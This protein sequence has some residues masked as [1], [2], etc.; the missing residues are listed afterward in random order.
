MEEA[1]KQFL[2]AATNPFY[3]APE[4]PYANIGTCAHRHGQPDKAADY[5]TRALLLNPNIPS[6][7]FSMS[8]INYG[9]RDYVAAQDYLNRYIKLKGQSPGTLWL[10]I[11]IER[12]LGNKDKVSS[13]ALLLRNKYPD[14]EE[15]KLLSESGIR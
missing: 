11:R 7:L 13:N 1:E 6:A 14:S 3:D 10:A 4:I 15:A 5:Y 2:A 8:E 12:E 9:R